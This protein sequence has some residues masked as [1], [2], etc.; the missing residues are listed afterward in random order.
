MVKFE[1]TEDVGDG[2]EPQVQLKLNPKMIL[3]LFSF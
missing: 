1:N 3:L 2:F